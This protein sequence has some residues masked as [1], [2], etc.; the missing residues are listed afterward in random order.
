MADNCKCHKFE[1]MDRA[2]YRS[3]RLMESSSSWFLCEVSAMIAGASDE[4]YSVK[5]MIRSLRDKTMSNYS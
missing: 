5:Q 2:W 3:K 4:F 1:L